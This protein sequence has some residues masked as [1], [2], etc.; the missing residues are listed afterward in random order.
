MLEVARQLVAEAVALQPAPVLLAAVPAG[1][2]LPEDLLRQLELAAERLP[3]VAL[4]G[5]GR[6]PPGVR[7]GQLAAG[8]PARAD[9]AVA[10]VSPYYAGAL[11]A[12]PP[13]GHDA[14]GA[15]DGA[16]T[17]SRDAAM[18]AAITLLDRVPPTTVRL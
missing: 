17:F 4:L 12:R 7:G 8:D 2:Q 10:V 14:A 13:L 3:L 18:H 5:A 16:L 6:C 11:A 9:L 15:Y 1:E